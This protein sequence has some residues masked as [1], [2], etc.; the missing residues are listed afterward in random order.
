MQWEEDMGRGI[1]LWLFG[2]PI[3]FRYCLA[4]ELLQLLQRP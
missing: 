1:L 2:V 4:A 3:D